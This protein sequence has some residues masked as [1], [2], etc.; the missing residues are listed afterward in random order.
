MRLTLGLVL[1][2][3]AVLAAYSQSFTVNVVDESG[4]TVP[5]YRWLLQED[6]TYDIKP[7]MDPA[8]YLAYGF[9]TS[10]SPPVATGC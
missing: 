4:T 9:H 8:D 7:G 6:T 2:L 3:G 10:Y 1:L 5:A